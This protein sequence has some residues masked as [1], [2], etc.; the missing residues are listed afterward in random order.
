M[1][2]FIR[3]HITL[4][5]HADRLQQ[6]AMIMEL[7]EVLII[8]NL[9]QEQTQHAPAAK[10]ATTTAMARLAGRLATIRLQIPPVVPATLQVVTPDKLA[11]VAHAQP[12]RTTLSM[13]RGAAAEPAQLAVVI[14]VVAV[15]RFALRAI[16]RHVLNLRCVASLLI[17]ALP[18]RLAIPVGAEQTALGLALT[19][20]IPPI[21]PLTPVG[22]GSTAVGTAVLATAPARNP[23]MFIA[24]TMFGA[25]WDRIAT[26]PAPEPNRPLPAVAMPAFPATTVTFAPR[27]KHATAAALA[28][29]A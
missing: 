4:L 15:L 8:R 25:E 1:V 3:V 29:A 11:Q 13:L 2:V 27:A 24:P 16:D 28:P 9:A 5:V 18:E 17:R 20:Q 21:A 6:H 26:A 19:A 10:S 23:E 22:I 12:A 7:H 14:L